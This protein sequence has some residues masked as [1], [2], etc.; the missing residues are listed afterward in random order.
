MVKAKKLVY[1][2]KSKELKEIYIE[3]EPTITK[4]PELIDLALL[5][6]LLVVAK[7]KGWI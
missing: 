6:K 1:D 2:V 4:E 5:K 7:N 3:I